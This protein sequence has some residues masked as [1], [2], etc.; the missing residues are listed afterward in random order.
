MQGLLK[1]SNGFQVISFRSLEPA[2]FHITDVSLRLTLNNQL[3]DRL[4]LVRLFQDGQHPAL[5]D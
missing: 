5:L 3:E 1:K 2:Q 4:G